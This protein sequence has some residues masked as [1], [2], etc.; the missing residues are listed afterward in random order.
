[1]KLEDYEDVMLYE[2]TIYGVPSLQVG[3]SDTCSFY[4]D[5]IYLLSRTSDSDLPILS[6]KTCTVSIRI[7]ES[8]VLRKNTVYPL[9]VLVY[10]YSGTESKS[11]PMLNSC[12]TLSPKS[13]GSI[14]I[15]KG[16]A[17]MTIIV[18]ARCRRSDKYVSK[19]ENAYLPSYVVCAVNPVDEKIAL[20]TDIEYPS[21]EDYL[22]DVNLAF[23]KIR[24]FLK[25][26]HLVTVYD[27]FDNEKYQTS[28][29]D[30]I[31]GLGCRETS[32]DVHYITEKE[33]SY[34]E[35]VQEGFQLYEV[36]PLESC[37]SW[38]FAGIY[39]SNLEASTAKL[40]LPYFIS[41]NTTLRNCNLDTLVLPD[42]VLRKGI[43]ITLI[44]CRIN[45]VLLPG[46]T[47]NYDL[48]IEDGF[49]HNLVTSKGAK[50]PSIFGNSRS[51]KVI[52]GSDITG[53]S[54]LNIGDV[55]RFIFAQP[56]YSSIENGYLAIK[57]HA[58]VLELKDAYFKRQNGCN[59]WN[60]LDFSYDSICG[61]AIIVGD[62]ECT[63]L[64]V[65]VPG[66]LPMPSDKVI[67]L[68]LAGGFKLDLEY[69]PFSTWASDVIVDVDDC[70][71]DLTF[72]LYKSE[73]FSGQADEEMHPVNVLFEQS[74]DKKP[75][76]TVNLITS[77]CVSVTL[78]DSLVA[79][80][81]IDWVLYKNEN[82]ARGDED[83][84]FMPMISRWTKSINSLRLHL[85][86]YLTSKVD[87]SNISCNNFELVVDAMYGYFNSYA[88]S[89]YSCGSELIV[90]LCKIAK[91]EIEAALLVGY[92]DLTRCTYAMVEPSVTENKDAMKGGIVQHRLRAVLAKTGVLAKMK[93][94]LTSFIDNVLITQE[95][96][97]FSEI[98][99]LTY[100]NADYVSPSTF[101]Q[102]DTFTP[103]YALIE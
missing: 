93:S 32:P 95:L 46:S 73:C 79:G 51:V 66:L 9:D 57:G 69:I 13:D 97:T 15:I 28:T 88:I 96:S 1:M 81:D 58:H 2:G 65:L 77:E 82:D 90:P 72:G 53:A 25:T 41:Q 84:R 22:K 7:P 20:M 52:V 55:D 11:Q 59:A 33:L 34:G 4:M 56:S 98:S 18:L 99:S 40:V 45:N 30:N 85:T 49:I 26:G 31:Y 47:A 39:L 44:N 24:G 5:I 63:N 12:L 71:D 64:D 3:Y 89:D 103:W 67:K 78:L 87:L 23:G 75:F 42:A 37:Y 43:M 54:I 35:H 19:F 10:S 76:K 102:D 61:D 27:D 101:P 60:F 91:L 14:D 74:S 94:E 21:K 38:S 16:T 92:L 36:L 86:S 8:G 83:R 62:S 6:S 68:R 100:V 17:D 50:K 29:R 48:V 80:A 70:S